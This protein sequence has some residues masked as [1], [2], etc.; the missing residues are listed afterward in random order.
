MVHFNL[1]IT[2]LLMIS[3]TIKAELAN[4]V[5]DIRH[6]GYAEDPSSQRVFPTIEDGDDAVRIATKAGIDRY[7]G[8]TIEGYD[9]PGSFYYDDLAGRRLYLLYDTQQGLFVCDR[10]GRVYRYSITLGHSEQILHLGQLIQE[11]TILNKLCLSNSGTWWT[12][13]DRGLYRRE[14][15]HRIIVVLRG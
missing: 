9:L 14:A 13:T 2:L 3:I 11:G 8:H 1:V 6:V 12:G 15:S 5:S 4:R 10:T 7:N